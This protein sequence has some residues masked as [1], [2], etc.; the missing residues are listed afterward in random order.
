[1]T[2]FMLIGQKDNAVAMAK[3]MRNQFPFVGVKSPDRK[4]QSKE[5]IKESKQMSLKDL[6][7]LI[8]KLYSRHEREYQNVAI[9]M[10][11]A[12][13]KRLSWRELKSLSS[14][15]LDRPWW[16]TVDAWRKIY[17][18]YIKQHRTDKEMVFDFFYSHNDFWMR[19]I[20]IT[21]QL[22]EKEQTDTQLLEKAILKDLKTE[23]F[24]IQKA[25]GWSL[26][27]YSKTN[28]DWVEGFISKVELSPL[29]KRE[30]LKQI[31]K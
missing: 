12:N 2:E 7:E 22:M 1:M 21:L 31:Q 11:E 20:G 5:L 26:R 13:I 28:P 30:G 24:F 17:S 18:L 29:A 19:R 3:Y 16:D 6:E 10:C 14:L 27:Q 8:R 23:E 9:D 4:N 25:I 15:I